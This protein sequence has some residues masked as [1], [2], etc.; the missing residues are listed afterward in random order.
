MWLQEKKYAWV[1]LAVLWIVALI[2]TIP[3]FVMSFY[4]MQIAEELHVL[5]SF[6]SST[7]AFNLFVTALCL[8]IGGWLEQKYGSKRILLAGRLIAAAGAI[9]TYFSHAGA[10]WFFL[11]YGVL[12]GL[13]GI[14]A[15]T[16]F[17]LLFHWFTAKRGMANTILRNA[18][19]LG[20]A[21]I[22]PI[23]VANRDWLS[24]T[25]GF[26][27]T[28]ILG[29]AISW[30]LIHFFVKD[31]KKTAE[32]ATDQVREKNAGKPSWREKTRQLMQMASSPVMFAVILALFTCGFNMGTVEMNLV[33]IHDHALVSKVEIGYALTVL[34]IMDVAGSFAFGYLLDRFSRTKVLAFIY[35]LRTLGFI[36]LLFHL[37]ISP[38]FFSILFGVTYVGVVPG[39]LLVAS[40]SLKASSGQTGVLLLIHSA[41]G[42]VGSMLGGFVYDLTGT[43]QALI[44]GNVVLC[45]LCVIC[46][47]LAVNAS[48]KKQLQS[49][50][51][52]S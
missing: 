23:F 1:L 37:P 26:L 11:G 42:I 34:G 51:Q 33:A 36:L 47:G 40:E 38:L 44:M 28:S 3:R 16:E 43:Y 29:L 2:G 19:P 7:W 6:V 45:F 4:Q 52:E 8:P 15:T 41:G 5:R 9:V 39:S 14:S 20:L 50:V 10:I 17:T 46:Y 22:S 49:A 13:S 32:Q 35:L 18:S 30:P 12:F 25:D 27:L 24:W 31:P 48:K 21:V